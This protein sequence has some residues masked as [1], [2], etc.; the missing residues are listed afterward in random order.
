M[1]KHNGA[2]WKK[3]DYDWKLGKYKKS[4]AVF[5]RG[6]YIVCIHAEKSYIIVIWH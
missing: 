4:L 1:E 2:V 5:A 3:N 6:E